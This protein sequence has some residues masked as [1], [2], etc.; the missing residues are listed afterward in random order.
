MKPE[1]VVGEI[2]RLSAGMTTPVYRGQAEAGWKL[3]SGALRRLKDAYG[4]DLPG[5]ENELR[6]L[7]DRYHSEKLILP[8]EVLDGSDLSKLQRLAVLQ[9]QRAATGL[10]DFTK[11][12]LVALWF[13]CDELPDSD[14]RVFVLDIENHEVAR[15]G[16][17]MK[18]PFSEEQVVVYFE[19]DRSLG[20]RIIAQQS[21]FVIGNPHIP[22]RFVKSIVVPR[23]SKKELRGYLEGLGLSETALFGDIPGLAAANTADTKMRVMEPLT[24]DQYRNRGNRAYQAGRLEE[25]LAAYESY[26]AVA[27]GVAQPY[28]LQGDALAALGR[29][30]EANRAYTSAID[31][32]AQPMIGPGGKGIAVNSMSTAMSRSLYYNRGNVRA[33]SGD[34]KGAVEDFD[35]ALRQGMEPKTSV[36]FNRGN[37]K[38][39][40]GMFEE[41]HED[42]E[43]VWLAG[44][45]SGAALGMGNCKVMMGK[46]EAAL[47]RY[48]NGSAVGTD[49]SAVHCQNNGEQ[50]Q[51][52]LQTLDGNKF[53]LTHAGHTV[54]VE[55]EGLEGLFAFTGNKGNTGNIPSG[56]VGTP[57]GEGY[58]GVDGFGV[59]IVPTTA[60]RV[61]S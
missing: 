27:P 40:L 13:A 21:V 26:A 18:D 8:M 42:F 11:Y 10:L 19:P 59:A 39:A 51:R 52:L 34:H 5:T 36:L 1:E 37:S 15:N 28:C 60:R 53:R 47:E 57:G 55:T 38:F 54:V 46:F 45:Q 24:A 56:L 22:D 50:V 33:A 44:E 2:L 35:I 23:Q 12:P 4:D 32:L 20:A 3:Q 17:L 31:N 58:E 7:V 29:F 41:A 43:A 14:G 6:N 9:H 16:R 49:G 30:E 48:V 25:A 61:E